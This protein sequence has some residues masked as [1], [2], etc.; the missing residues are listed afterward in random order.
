MNNEEGYQICMPYTTHVNVDCRNEDVSVE[1]DPA[2]V[3]TT[4]VLPGTAISPEMYIPGIALRVAKGR[5]LIMTVLMT[6]DQALDYLKALATSVVRSVPEK[7][8]QA[9]LMVKEGMEEA[10]K[11]SARGPGCDG[12][13]QGGEDAPIESIEGRRDGHLSGCEEDDPH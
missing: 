10:L 13:L 3:F 11:D 5:S 1:V 7:L 4:S 6:G 8:D 9:L 12:R 2:M